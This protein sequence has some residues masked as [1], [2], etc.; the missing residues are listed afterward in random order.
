[1]DL[2]RRLQFWHGRTAAVTGATGFV[3]FHLARLLA[4]LGARVVAVAR[5]GSDCARLAA[6]GVA[7]HEAA[8]DDPAAL[9]RACRGCA[10]VFHTA[11]V[12]DFGDDWPRCRRVNFEGSRNAAAAARAAG[13]R[14]VHTSS[15]VAIGAGPD[16]YPLD[17]TARWELGR[18]AVPYVSTKRQ[19]EEAVLAVGAVVVNPACV[20]GP[21]DFRK[22]EFGT[23]CYRFWK[24]RLPVHF[25][26]GNNFADVRDVAVGHLLAAERGQAG[27]RYILGG[28]NRT[29]TAFFAE[30]A[31]AARRWIGRV[32]LP[33]TLAPLAAL[34][35]RGLGRRGGR[36]YLTAG[37]AR[38]VPLY[39][40]YD[41]AKA[42]R[43]L[44]YEPRPLA[45]TLADAHAF[46]MD[47]RA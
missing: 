30:L 14:L 25:G 9:A 5:S 13:A 33:N 18:L 16:P 24:G 42:R 15:V 11:G 32:R 8:L 20:V 2:Q 40:W 7:I 26:G 19:A 31:R 22:S 43:E 36:P 34:I 28:A 6:A 45:V 23:L 44:G 17:E 12:V 38:L 46:W 27:Q 35:S 37:Q 3:G 10:F 1:M 4:T 41:S 39:F 21:D 47:R 29:Y